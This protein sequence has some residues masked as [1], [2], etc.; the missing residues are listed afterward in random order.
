MIV[1]LHWLSDYVDCGN[2]PKDIADA[3]TS[4]GYMLDKPIFKLNGE[5]I[6]DLE[7]RQNRPD[8]LSLYGLAREL[9]AF[10]GLSLKKIEIEEL[11]S[12]ADSEPMAIL[13]DEKLCYRFNI[14]LIKDIIISS[15]PDWIKQKLL[16]YGIEPI[17]SIV[18][19]TNFIMIE[20][21]QPLHA[22]DLD[23][24]KLP[25]IIEPIVNNET[26]WETLGGNHINLTDGDLVIKDASGIQALAGIIG[27]NASRVTENTTSVLLEAAT[28]KQSSI[29]QTSRRHSLR[30]EASLRFEKFIHPE[31]TD[32]ALKRAAFLMNQI[33]THI[34]I[35]HI[36]VYPKPFEE[37]TI[38]I[39]TENI[40]KIGGISVK[41]DE[42]LEILGRLHIPCRIDEH[43]NMHITVPYWRTDL[44]CEADIVEDILRM[45]DYNT[46]PSTPLSAAVP[47]DIQDKMYTLEN[48]VRE[49]MLAMGYDEQITE[50]LTH[51][52]SPTKKP[53]ILVNSLTS[54][55][56]MLQTTLKHRLINGLHNRE[57]YRHNDI[58]LFEVGKIYFY[59]D[60][61][62]V[63]NN[64][65]SAICKSDIINF[66]DFKGHIDLLLDK[67]GYHYNSNFIN[68]EVL[69]IHGQEAFFFEL[70]LLRLI[71]N[72]SQSDK[73]KTYTSPP[74][75][76]LEDLSFSIPED[77]KV[78]DVINK[79]MCLDDKIH[80]IALG[81][82]PRVLDNNMKSIFLKIQFHD[83]NTSLSRVDIVP[84]KEN[85]IA[86]LQSEFGA[87]IKSV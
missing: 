61:I 44:E 45:K 48:S 68:I 9:A 32:L 86:L 22:F 20:T 23:N 55:K 78:G 35:E 27:G 77:I 4:I 75:L 16:A 36:D 30:T 71:E 82:K 11:E 28:Y 83:E 69:N 72:A 6:L 80:H 21:G 25:L 17:N 66:Y 60:E 73:Y 18:D 51:E 33:F 63:E 84:I 79:L 62:P 2:N 58:R 10:K 24:I 31:L 67:L 3:F 29:R 12:H 74:Q 65:V 76:I 59:D 42:V 87:A 52:L 50:P 49:M 14:L 1:P 15:S 81:E 43:Q 56:S 85:I 57:K 26:R 40:Q 13:R 37:K 41:N 39:S 19:I 5:A 46:I 8:C 53:I 34:S 70:N 54:E 7:V 64:V 38:H 47:T